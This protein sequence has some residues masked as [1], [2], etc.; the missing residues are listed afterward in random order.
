MSSAQG[1]NGGVILTWD[2]APGAAGYAIF[3]SPVAVGGFEPLS[4]DDRTDGFL[5]DIDR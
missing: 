3:R 5:D 2:A 1:E 4:V